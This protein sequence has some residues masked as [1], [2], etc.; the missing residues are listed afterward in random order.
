MILIAKFDE[1]S[2]EMAEL[3]I[4]KDSTNANLKDFSGNNLFHVLANIVFDDSNL[5]NKESI[6]E[7]KTK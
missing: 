3:L 6:R 5:L 1:K 2:Y 4:N 7:Y